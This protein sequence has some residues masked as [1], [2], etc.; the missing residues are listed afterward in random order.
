[1]LLSVMLFQIRLAIT[2]AFRLAITGDCECNVNYI[3]SYGNVN[4]IFF[5]IISN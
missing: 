5:A 2:D 1:M 3:S 4:K